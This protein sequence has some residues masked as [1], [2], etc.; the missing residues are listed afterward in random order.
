MAGRLV[1][2]A[3]AGL[4][5]MAG[6]ALDRTDKAIETEVLSEADCVFHVERVIDAD[7]FEGEL[8]LPYN[9]ALRHQRLRVLG[10]DA[11]ELRGEE[12]P[13]GIAARDAVED[14]LSEA[15]FL[16]VR[17]AGRPRDNFGRLLGEVYV[18]K[19]SGEWVEL[20]AFLEAGGHTKPRETG[21]KTARNRPS[22]RGS[23]GPSGGG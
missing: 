12:K 20:R 2:I 6:L 13:R 16:V 19:R 21:V 11:W 10:V 18:V 15:A 3:S 23:P 17:P 7:T 5:M 22:N 8:V 9:V 1:I 4:A 14:L